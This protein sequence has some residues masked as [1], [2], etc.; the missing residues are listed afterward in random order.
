MLGL[1]Y[2]QFPIGVKSGDAA[3]VGLGVEP[4]CLAAEQR[5]VEGL[6]RALVVQQPHVKKQSASY[7]A[8]NGL[9][10]LRCVSRIRPTA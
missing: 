8:P 10:P 9:V 1:E 7:G 5:A 6:H 4:H 2:G 3:T